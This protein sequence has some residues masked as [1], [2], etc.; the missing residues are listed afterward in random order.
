MRMIVIHRSIIFLV[1]V[2]YLFVVIHIIMSCNYLLSIFLYNW[3]QP[4]LLKNKI[5]TKY[6]P[7]LVGGEVTKRSAGQEWKK[8]ESRARD[9]KVYSLFWSGKGKSQRGVDIVILS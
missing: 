9:Y 1:F 5:K 2:V 6:L 7:T 8:S 3:D 4:V